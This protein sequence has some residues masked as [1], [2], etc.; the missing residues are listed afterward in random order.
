MAKTR[1]LGG[2]QGLRQWFASEDGNHYRGMT[3]DT[4]AVIKHVERMDAKVNGAPKA[5]NPNGWQYAGSV[6]IAVVVDWCHKH[7]CTFDQ[8]ARDDGGLKSKFLAELR[9]RDYHKLFRRD[10]KVLR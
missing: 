2:G 3:Q 9:S 4:D 10:G 1:P 7:G 5:V 8:W 6:P